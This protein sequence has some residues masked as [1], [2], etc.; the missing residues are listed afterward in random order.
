[1]KTKILD[2]IEEITLGFQYLKKMADNIKYESI[3]SLEKNIEILDTISR[4]VNMATGEESGLEKIY[5]TLIA[6]NDIIYYYLI[7]MRMCDKR[8]KVK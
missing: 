6:Q 4:F 7:N 8:G 3:L 2:L 5:E 1:M